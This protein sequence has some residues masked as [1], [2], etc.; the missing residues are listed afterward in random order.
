MLETMSIA[1]DVQLNEEDDLEAQFED[2]KYC[3]SN[4]EQFE[5]TRLR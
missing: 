4:K 5:C 1:I 2:L 3:L